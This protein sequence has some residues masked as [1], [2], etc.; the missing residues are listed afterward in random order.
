[1]L[2]LLTAA[3]LSAT[4]AAAASIGPAAADP[5][6][7]VLARE[8]VDLIEPPATRDKMFA[9]SPAMVGRMARRSIEENPEFRA[10]FESDP[11]VKT[12]VDR[13]IERVEARVTDSLKAGI[14]AVF[15][16]Q[17]DAFARRLTISEL[18]ALIIF[19]RTPAGQAYALV[20]SDILND[21]A[22]LAARSKMYG[23]L[24][25]QSDLQALLAELRGLP[26][27]KP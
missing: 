27:A 22:V 3:V 9:S 7:L 19:F 25:V 16:A 10:Q 2:A 20:D 11:R 21:P 13:Y 14:P 12:I 8:F 26:K 15:E 6:R 5:A 4:S 17:A 23:Q 1:M 24:D 18:H